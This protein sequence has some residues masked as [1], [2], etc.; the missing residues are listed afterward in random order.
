[1]F[2]VPRIIIVSISNCSLA[3]MTRIR[4]HECVWKLVS[5]VLPVCSILLQKDKLGNS[6]EGLKEKC[7]EEEK[8]VRHEGSTHSAK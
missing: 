3:D 1:M 8:Q 4:M 2:M 5:L 6:V 7:D